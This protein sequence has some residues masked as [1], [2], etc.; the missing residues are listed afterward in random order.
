MLKTLAFAATI[1]LTAFNS[2]FADGAA[3]PGENVHV[4]RFSK[5]DA[6][7]QDGRAHMLRTI[8]RTARKLCGGEAQILVRRHCEKV[9]VETSL[10]SISDETLQ[11]ALE[12]D[13]NATQGGGH[14][15][16]TIAPE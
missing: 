8:E 4:M 5:A 13:L 1:T 16:S 6:A 10:A 7:T 11:A 9:F 2:A 14:V 15:L 3:Q 12:H